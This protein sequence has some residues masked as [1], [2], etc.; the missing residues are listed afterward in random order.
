MAGMILLFLGGYLAYLFSFF[1]RHSTLLDLIVPVVFFGGSWFV[2]LSTTLSLQ[3]ALDV[4]KVS[5][6]ERDAS[7]DSLTG[8]FNRRYLDRRLTDE[9]AA[10]RRY[11]LPLALMMLD[12]DHFKRVNDSFGH[13]AGDKVL[14]EVAR[15]VF[16]QLRETDVFA[17]YGGEEFMIVA[18]HT[19]LPDVITLAERIRRNI[20]Q[21]VFRVPDQ[22]GEISRI[23]LTISI[24]LATLGP[25]SDDKQSLIRFAD[26]SLMSAKAAGRN[27]VMHASLARTAPD[28]DRTTT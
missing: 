17:R 19:V 26:A 18:P 14:V 27:R 21:H 3:T 28:A 12:L 20:E 23:H 7:T 10:A 13:Q 6:L 4:M 16:R 8:I 11:E 5:A 22:S 9:I 1:D 2:L 25:G 24:G 15:E